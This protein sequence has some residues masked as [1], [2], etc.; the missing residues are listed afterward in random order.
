MKSI[1]IFWCLIAC[2]YLY[3]SIQ[4]YKLYK[5]IKQIG[6]VFIGKGKISVGVIGL[7]NPNYKEQIDIGEIFYKLLISDM[8]SFL[9]A[10]I[11]AIITALILP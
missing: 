1:I 10:L 11:G 3:L 4:T 9:L 2:G 6:G 8:F 7:G 5:R